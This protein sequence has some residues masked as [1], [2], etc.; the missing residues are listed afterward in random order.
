LAAY[1]LLEAPSSETFLALTAALED[2]HLLF[3]KDELTS[4]YQCAL[5]HCIRRINAGQ[6]EAYADALA[7]YRSL[8]D[9]GLL[10][11]HGGRLS[12][13]AY[14]NIATTGLRTGAFEWTE[15]FLHQYR[16]AL[17]PAE[18]DN[19]FA[20]NLAT[21]YF[22]KQELAS[23]LQTL[24][25][26]EFT[27][28][29][30]HVGAKILQLKTFYLLNEADALI[31]LLA[32][33]EQLLR[34]DKTLS[35]FGKATNLNFLRMLRQANKWKMKKARLSVLKAK[36]ERLTLIEKVAALQPLANKDWLLKVLSGEE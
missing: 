15:Q 35:P 10:L 32:T 29:T 12:Q 20:F 6:P 33:T 22:E 28:F 1:D 18:R 8:L 36:R 3:E 14:K 26:V 7:L 19:A 30:Y 31:S 16:D 11:Q 21:L 24:Q 17:P 5:N 13:W 25:N 2:H 9:R 23:T 27:D 34:R 4:L